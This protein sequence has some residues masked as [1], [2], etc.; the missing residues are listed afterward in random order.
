VITKSLPGQN[1]MNR[2]RPVQTA[3]HK[4]FSRSSRHEGSAATASACV[5][6]EGLGFRDNDRFNLARLTP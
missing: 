5:K 2:A 6:V 1:C 3:D 4:S